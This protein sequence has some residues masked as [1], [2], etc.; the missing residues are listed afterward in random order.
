[1]PV[2]RVLAGTDSKTGTHVWQ[3]LGSKRGDL[4]IRG[5]TGSHHSDLANVLLV[6][7]NTSRQ[8]TVKLSVGHG[9]WAARYAAQSPA[10]LLDCLV[11]RPV[12]AFRRARAT[13]LVHG[14]L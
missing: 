12:R 14:K 1:M 10:V 9:R 11:H 4:A 7:S 2:F 8:V 5:A 3:V 13:F 6:T